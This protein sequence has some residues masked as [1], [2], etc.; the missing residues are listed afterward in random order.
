MS[1][2]LFLT[3]LVIVVGL[4]ASV[5]FYAWDRAHRARTTP[6]RIRPETWPGRL[7]PDQAGH[8]GR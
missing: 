6:H 7:P 1:L 4:A 2:E 5:A 3:L 8:R